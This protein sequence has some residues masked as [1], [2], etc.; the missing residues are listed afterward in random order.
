[1]NTLR[2]LKCRQCKAIKQGKGLHVPLGWFCSY[3]HATEFALRQNDRRKTKQEKE[4]KKQEVAERKDRKE[5]LK[6]RKW[7]LKKAQQEFNKWI[8][9]RD[10]NEPCISCQRH[11]TGQYHAGHYRTTAAAPQLR[12]NQLNC[13][14]QC[15]ACNNHKSG[16]VGEYRINLIKKIGIESLESIEN[17]SE[18]KNW[19]IEEFKAVCKQYNPKS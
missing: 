14:K 6:D 11:H 18:L 16:N 9:E 2:N 3:E 12:F 15:S 10:K 7:W 17:S 19:S 8:R 13:H 4:T 5:R 1:M